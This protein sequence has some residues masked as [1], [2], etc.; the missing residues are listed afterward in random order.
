MQGV[1]PDFDERSLGFSRFSDVMRELEKAGV[2]RVEFD[3]AH[4][5]LLKIL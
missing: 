2:L 4:S 5:M 3:E 1:Y